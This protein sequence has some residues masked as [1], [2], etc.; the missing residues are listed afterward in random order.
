VR[1]RAVIIPVYR[2]AQ[3]RSFVLPGTVP[4]PGPGS[5]AGV[6]ILSHLTA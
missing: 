6:I 4:V 1:R 3:S 5:S 2:M